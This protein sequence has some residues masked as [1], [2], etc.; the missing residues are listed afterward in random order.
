[1][2]RQKEPSVKVFTEKF[3]DAAKLY[4]VSIREDRFLASELLALDSFVA[5]LDDTP[6]FPNQFITIN[7]ATLDVYPLGLSPLIPGNL[8]QTRPSIPT[9]PHRPQTLHSPNQRP[10][11]PPLNTPHRDYNNHPPRLIP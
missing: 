4:D 1:M 9:I 3:G 10:T 11:I 6:L 2:I 5:Q 8:S 7:L